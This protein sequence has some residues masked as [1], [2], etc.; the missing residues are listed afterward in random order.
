MK[1]TFRVKRTKKYQRKTRTRK[2]RG[3][4]IVAP[5]KAQTGDQLFMIAKTQLE[6]INKNLKEVVK[7]DIVIHI[8]RNEQE[9]LLY[10]QAIH[11]HDVIQTHLLNIKELHKFNYI[12]LNVIQ[13]GVIY[14]LI[15]D[16]ITKINILYNALYN[17]NVTNVR[18]V[19]ILDIENDTMGALNNLNK[20]FSDEFFKKIEPKFY[21]NNSNRENKRRKTDN[22]TKSSI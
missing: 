10:A 17:Y 1:K 3:G 7:E 15:K 19:K 21:D 14:N 8:E 18:D 20:S 13:K 12:H 16:I 9:R 2:S 6:G 22:S 11:L 4:S 5:T